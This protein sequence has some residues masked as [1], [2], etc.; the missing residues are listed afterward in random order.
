MTEYILNHDQT[1]FPEDHTLNYLP[2]DH[3]HIRK[4]ETQQVIAA[5][6]HLRARHA[7]YEAVM[8]LW[9]RRQEE[10]LTVNHLSQRIGRSPRWIKRALNGPEKWTLKTFGEL[11]EAM[12]GEI[13]IRALPDERSIIEVLSDRLY[14]KT[15]FLSSVNKMTTFPEFAELES[16][17]R[18]TVRFIL[19]WMHLG[20]V[21]IFWFPLLRRI[22][23]EDPVPAEDR[24]RVDE[25]R[26][27]WV[28]WGQENEIWGKPPQ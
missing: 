10:G 9:R 24:G 16:Y 6:G 8:E 20:E 22:T 19:S 14:N 28:A 13:E 7:S 12:E 27:R 25:M 1:A 17:G 4:K 23:G 3:D 18:H 26:K 21:K 2:I 15:C 11:V 5:Y